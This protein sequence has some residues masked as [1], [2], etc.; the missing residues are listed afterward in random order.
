MA[1]ESSKKDRI[2]Q[3]PTVKGRQ[4]KGRNI[5][6]K[7]VFVLLWNKKFVIL[8]FLIVV[9]S[10][11]AIWTLKSPKQ[12][13][14]RVRLLIEKDSLD[15][16]SS[17]SVFAVDTTT[18]DYFKTQCSILESRSLA[19]RVIITLRL[20]V[21]DRNGEERPMHPLEL[22]PKMKV[23]PVRD[24]RLVDVFVENTD[25]KQ[26]AD[27]ANAIADEFIRFNV[28]SKIDARKAAATMIGKQ[29]EDLAEEVAQAEARFNEFRQSNNIASIDKDQNPVY[30]KLTVFT[31]EVSLREREAVAAELTYSRI[32]DMSIEELK[33]QPEITED[34]V[35][36]QLQAGL[37]Q[38]EMQLREL[39]L[40]YGE[41]H[42][43]IKTK[44]DA[45]AKINEQIEATATAIRQQLKEAS[46]AAK[47]KHSRALTE[48]GKVQ[49]QVH[50]FDSVLAAYHKLEM[51][52][53]SKNTT[54][55]DLLG[56][57]TESTV[58]TGVTSAPT[59]WETGTSNIRVV[60]RAEV[61]GVPFRP[62]PFVNMALAVF[63]GLL[64]GCGS[65]FFLEYLHDEVKNPDDITED[66]GRN[67]LAMIPKPKKNMASAKNL[68]KIA[69]FHPS[70]QVSEA[71]RNLQTSIKL[72]AKDG[73]F[74]SLL[75]TSVCPGEGKTTTAENLSIVV[76]QH[77]HKV[78]LIDTDMRRPRI[79]RDFA[80]KK[81]C[82][83]V[84][85]LTRECSLDEALVDM[86]EMARGK[87]P[88]GETDRE[89]EGELWIL[90]CERRFPNPTE[91]I[92]SPNMQQLMV[93]LQKRFDVV[94]YD[95]PPLQFSDPLLL[96]HAV[97]G[98]VIVIEAHKYPK[99]LIAQGLERLDQLE[100]GKVF[101]VVLN[102]YEPKRAGGY[103]YYGYRSYYYY[104]YYDRYYYPY[105]GQSERGRSWLRRSSK[106]KAGKEKAKAK[107][108]PKETT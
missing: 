78:L 51:E 50:A 37:L 99:P 21:T 39:S 15:L 49:Q 20:R 79:H 11:T 90:P 76:A 101:G 73:R 12:Y 4:R 61:P 89:K 34:T 83:L 104:R 66:L 106:K 56:R 28:T 68:S 5:H 36:Q 67:L 72:M 24:T 60:D 92:G 54:Y 88:Q 93:E 47:E 98:I 10:I 9:S 23:A 55:K 25:P 31:D 62:R 2:M 82:G 32:Q 19:E 70:G 74:P 42:P 65:A 58:E 102:K 27:I 26:A 100:E 91:A 8:L 6:I 29:L 84:K 95:S 69:F 94:I 59:P 7:D 86:S 40:R 45:I 52:V 44:N 43:L 14:T 35:I 13:R 105:Y 80:I 53:E 103:G 64:L 17:N 46:I 85:Y 87:Q 41:K 48:L 30:K 16:F 107:T 108:P 57:E 81:D 77:G 96:A 22:R 63:V 3:K 38:T 71:Y 75:I 18:M 1:M 33:Q 97:D